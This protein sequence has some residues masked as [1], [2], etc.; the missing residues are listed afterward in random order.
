MLRDRQL[1]ITLRVNHECMQYR[2]LLGALY[3]IADMETAHWTIHMSEQVSQQ[4]ARRRDY[5]KRTAISESAATIN[6]I[7]LFVNFNAAVP[8]EDK[9]FIL[10]TGFEEPQPQPSSQTPKDNSLKQY[11][12]N[13]SNLM[14]HICMYVLTNEPE[15]CTYLNYAIDI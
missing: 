4:A 3:S 14:S 6:G 9:T 11:E 12:W 13:C 2:L 7:T 8:D 5:S 15:R 10:C 1:V